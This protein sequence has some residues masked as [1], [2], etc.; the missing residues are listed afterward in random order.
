MIALFEQYPRLEHGIPHVSVGEYPTPV[1]RLKDLAEELGAGQLYIKRDDLNGNVYGGNKVRKMEFILGRVLRSGAREIMIIGRPDLKHPL[2]AAVCAHRAGLGSI[3]MLLPKYDGEHCARNLLMSH[4]YG[5][6]LHQGRNIPFLIM[7]AVAQLLRHQLRTGSVPR[8]VWGSRSCPLGTVGFV[9]AAF[10]LK[11]QIIDGEILEPDCIYVALGSMGTAVGL[12][13]GLKAAG[14]HS[15]VVPVGTAS[16]KTANR[17][18]MIRLFNRTVNLL[19]ISDPSFPRLG[20]SADEIDLR[21]DRFWRET[22][23]CTAHE[24]GARKRLEESEGVEL[25]DLYTAKAF[26]RLVNDAEKG[27]LRGKTVL[28][29]HTYDP[30]DFS[31]IIS[32][33]DYHDLPRCFHSYFE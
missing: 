9:N 33:L 3:S 11:K 18:K 29:W 26:T 13:V 24:S 17:R 25:D 15:Q 6:E 10:E 32:T 20:L 8:V 21:D 7:S 28:F 31:D 22:E 19:N 16:A 30:G 5:S 12:M 4:Y 14:L 2:T 27:D 1:H 23:L